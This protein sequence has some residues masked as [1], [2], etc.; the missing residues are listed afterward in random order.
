MKTYQGKGREIERRREAKR[1]EKRDTE[2]EE[3]EGERKGDKK[4]VYGWDVRISERSEWKGKR[5]RAAEA[6]VEKGS[7]A[8]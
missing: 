3:G 4:K 7:S 6:E 2:S 5:V 1:E 8:K